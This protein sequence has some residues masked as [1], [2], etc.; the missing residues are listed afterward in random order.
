VVQNDWRYRIDGGGE[1]A[2]LD[3]GS[4]AQPYDAEEAAEAVAMLVWDGGDPPETVEV[5]VR[6]GDVGGATRWR[7]DPEYSLSGWGRP[8]KRFA[9]ERCRCGCAAQVHNGTDRDCRACP[10]RKPPQ[11]CERFQPAT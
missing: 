6:L 9:R 3:E 11:T 7:V 8:L 1:W 10:G 4:D 5:E 2:R